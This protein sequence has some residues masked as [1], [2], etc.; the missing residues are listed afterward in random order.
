MPIGHD[1]RLICRTVSN[2]HGAAS[3]LCKMTIQ[4]CWPLLSK[5]TMR[6]VKIE[7]LNTIDH[8]AGGTGDSGA[9]EVEAVVTSD[10]L[11]LRQRVR[12]FG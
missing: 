4:Y 7:R 12:E 11:E 1:R 6:Y 10:E 3:N 2:T 5:Q 8:Q 9:R